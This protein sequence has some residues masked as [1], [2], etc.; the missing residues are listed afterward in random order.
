MQLQFEAAGLFSSATADAVDMGIGRFS[1]SATLSETVD[2]VTTDCDDQ[3][4]SSSGWHE[5]GRGQK[6][7]WLIA[8]LA[9]YTRR[10]ARPLSSPSWVAIMTGT[11]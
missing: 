3:A 7:K 4:P 11:A 2:T 10:A 1:Y 6:C 8:C 5:R 9:L